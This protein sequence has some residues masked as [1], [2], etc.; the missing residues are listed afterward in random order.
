[1]LGSFSEGFDDMLLF[2]YENI[3]LLLCLMF[4]M[5]L[6]DPAYNYVHPL[7]HKEVNIGYPKDSLFPFPTSEMDLYVRIIE[8]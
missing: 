1:M 3:S 6:T 4:N 7:G 2:I 5:V 8:N